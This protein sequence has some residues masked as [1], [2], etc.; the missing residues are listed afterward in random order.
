MAQREPADSKCRLT[1]PPER[2]VAERAHAR[3]VSHEIAL[4]AIWRVA[5]DAQTARI[6]SAIDSRIA[7]P[8]NGP[9]FTGADRAR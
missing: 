8:P 9:R 6:S 5:L 4:P 7:K 3:G 1:A 2:G